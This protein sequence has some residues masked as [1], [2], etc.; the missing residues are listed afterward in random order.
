MSLT[1]PRGVIQVHETEDSFAPI[2][3]SSR[4]NKTP[5]D[6]SLTGEEARNQ[7]RESGMSLE[8]VE[9]SQL[10]DECGRCGHTIILV[11]YW[12]CGKIGESGYRGQGII[13]CQSCDAQWSSFR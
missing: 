8:R 13:V 9:R 5:I 1:A 4:G 6:R 7:A 12:G 11:E 10:H 3:G 2:F